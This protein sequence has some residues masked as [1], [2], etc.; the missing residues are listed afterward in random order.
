MSGRPSGTTRILGPDIPGQPGHNSPPTI[1]YPHP[2]MS[3][4]W[5][6]GLTKVKDATR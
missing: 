5:T 4:T 1:P 6:C 3:E 2:S